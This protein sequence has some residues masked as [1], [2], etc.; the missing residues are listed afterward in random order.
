MMGKSYRDGK[1]KV[2]VVYVYPGAND[3]SRGRE[4]K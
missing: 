4:L 1:T 3:G 2:G